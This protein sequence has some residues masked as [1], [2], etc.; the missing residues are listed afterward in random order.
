MVPLESRLRLVHWQVPSLAVI[1]VKAVLHV[2]LA[3][4]K[5][6]LQVVVTKG[7]GTSCLWCPSAP[8]ESWMRLGHFQVLSMAGCPV[9]VLSSSCLFLGLCCLVVCLFTVATLWQVGQAG[10]VCFL[11]RLFVC[12]F[13][14]VGFVLAP[15]LGLL[16]AGP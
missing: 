6:V 5:G 8:L 2:K 11:G 7:D 1:G 16:V 15:E 12:V 4:E 9:L 10:C 14:P 3:E 13:E